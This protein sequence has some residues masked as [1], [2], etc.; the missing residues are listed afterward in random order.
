VCVVP[1]ASLAHAADEARQSLE[2]KIQQH[3]EKAKHAAV[4]EALHR[5]ED[6]LHKL[7]AVPAV[8]LLQGFPANLWQQLHTVRSQVGG[9]DFKE[10]GNPG[11]ARLQ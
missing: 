8:E 1:V 3:V 5:T 10:A 11:A 6:E 2:D 4:K 9:Y 7:I